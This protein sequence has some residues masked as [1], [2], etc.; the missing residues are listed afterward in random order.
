MLSKLFRSPV[1]IYECLLFY[2][3]NLGKYTLPIPFSKPWPGK[4]HVPYKHQSSYSADAW[5]VLHHRNKTHG[6]I[7]AVFISPWLVVWYRG[8][9]PTQ[10]YGDY[11]FVANIF[12]SRHKPIRISWNVSFSFF[13]SVAHLDSTWNHQVFAIGSRGF[14]FQDLPT[15]LEPVLGVEAQLWFFRCAAGLTHDSYKI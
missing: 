10:L 3:P 1:G 8:W 15:K 7:W 4:I 9:N 2:G 11:F 5:G 13:F 14:R 6:S 12:G